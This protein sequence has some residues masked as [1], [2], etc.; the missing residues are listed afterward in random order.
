MSGSASL[1][2]VDRQILDLLREDA[3]R[4]VA[5]IS[6]RVAL[7][8]APVQRRIA[9]LEREGV[10][11]GY[12]TVL[13]HDLIGSSIQAFVEIRLTGD[14][15]VDKV[16]TAFRALPEIRAAFTVAGDPDALLQIQVEDVAHLKKVVNQLR[17]TEHVRGTKTLMVLDSW[18]DDFA[19]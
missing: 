1:D 9:R 16:I 10:I 18:P 7:S 5:D 4:T 13:N 17:R 6:K 14:G 8:T 15:D 3:R 2:N 12:T 11:R 19:A